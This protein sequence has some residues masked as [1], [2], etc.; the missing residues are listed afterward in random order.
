MTCWGGVLELGVNGK[1]GFF[2]SLKQ[3]KEGL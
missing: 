3:G 2:F 1:G